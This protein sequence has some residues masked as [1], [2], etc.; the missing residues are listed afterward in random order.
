MLATMKKINSTPAQL[1]PRVKDSYDSGK[2][3]APDPGPHQRKSQ[4]PAHIGSL[5][6]NMQ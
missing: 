2:G 6:K 1:C 5:T 4:Q 3:L